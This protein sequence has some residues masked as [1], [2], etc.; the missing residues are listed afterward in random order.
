MCSVISTAVHVSR[1]TTRKH[2]LQKPLHSLIACIDASS[3][4]RPRLHTRCHG[5]AAMNASTISQRDST[6]RLAWCSVRTRLA[7][8]TSRQITRIYFFVDRTTQPLFFASS[9][10]TPSHICKCGTP[11]LPLLMAHPLVKTAFP[12]APVNLRLE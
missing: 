5:C 10:S 8:R 9:R 1:P 11:C 7:V 12:P 4:A 2:H 3:L 6:T